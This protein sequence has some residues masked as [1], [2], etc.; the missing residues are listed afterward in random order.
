MHPDLTNALKS[1]RPHTL[2]L[3]KTKIM[4]EVG[5]TPLPPLFIQGSGSSQTVRIHQRRKPHR[6]NNRASA[7]YYCLHS[8]NHKKRKGATKQGPEDNNSNSNTQEQQLTARCDNSRQTDST[9]KLYTQESPN[10]APPN[11]ASA[12]T[13]TGS[14]AVFTLPAAP[15]IPRNSR[16][17]REL[18]RSRHKQPSSYNLFAEE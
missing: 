12:M 9:N 18:L 1:V 17:M 15:R 8:E 13:T 16:D 14:A 10:A 11:R 6:S 4:A 2:G 7:R 3:E 5:T